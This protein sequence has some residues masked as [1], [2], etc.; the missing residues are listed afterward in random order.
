MNKKKSF[1]LIVCALVLGAGG[2]YV[3]NSL[4]AGKYNTINATC[5]LLNAA[6]DNHLLRPEQ[7]VELGRLTKARLG[8]TQAARVFHLSDEQVKS[9]SEASNCSQFMVGMSQPK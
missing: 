5:T 7:M 9:A 8:D 3:V 4:T 1:G 6:V 2:G